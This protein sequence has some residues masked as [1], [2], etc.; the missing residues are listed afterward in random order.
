MWL[1]MP[2]YLPFSR[3]KNCFEPLFERTHFFNLPDDYDDVFEKCRK[4]LEE[5]EERMS[6]EKE[7]MSREEQEMEGRIRRERE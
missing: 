4:K 2:N 5:M 1:M 3:C 6:R 7:R